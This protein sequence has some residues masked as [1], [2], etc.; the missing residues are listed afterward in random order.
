MDGSHLPDDDGTGPTNAQYQ[1]DN[2]AQ[3]FQDTRAVTVSIFNMGFK[4]IL[5]WNISSDLI[6][7]FRKQTIVLYY[8]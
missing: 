6:K 5:V 8:G 3:K 2:F 1:I 4:F 7:Y